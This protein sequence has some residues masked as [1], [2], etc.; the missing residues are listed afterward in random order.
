[1]AFQVFWMLPQRVGSEEIMN[2]F[3]LVLVVYFEQTVD[4]IV[5]VT[6]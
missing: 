6:G 5:T 4:T 1:M 3:N 2:G